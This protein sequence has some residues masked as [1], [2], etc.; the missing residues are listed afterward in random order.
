MGWFSEGLG[1]ICLLLV[2]FFRLIMEHFCFSSTRARLDF[3]YVSH[4]SWSHRM[5]LSGPILVIRMTLNTNMTYKKQNSSSRKYL[6]GRGGVHREISVRGQSPNLGKMS[7]TTVVSSYAGGAG[8]TFA[9]DPVKVRL[10]ATTPIGSPC[11]LTAALPDT[12]WTASYLQDWKDFFYKTTRSSTPTGPLR[13][14]DCTSC[15]DSNRCPP[16]FSST[17][18]TGSGKRWE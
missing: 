17:T 10:Q 3:L 12:S 8:Y 11:S 1:C 2:A 18:P 16:L 5:T 13:Q 9:A 4:I 15:M 6:S 14:P 7:A